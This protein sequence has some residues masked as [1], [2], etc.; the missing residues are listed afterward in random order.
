MGTWIRYNNEFGLIN[1][2]DILNIPLQTINYII[3]D[4]HGY[5]VMWIQNKPLFTLSHLLNNDT[6][7]M[8]PINVKSK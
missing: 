3:I 4:G 2:L 5:A 7:E 8:I 6:N 1:I